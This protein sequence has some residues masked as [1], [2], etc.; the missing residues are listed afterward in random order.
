MATKRAMRSS[1]RSS[2]NRKTRNS[3]ASSKAILPRAWRS[4]VISSK[5]VACG[6]STRAPAAFE[7]ATARVGNKS[8]KNHQREGVHYKRP[9]RTPRRSKRTMSQ[10]AIRAATRGAWPVERFEA[11]TQCAGYWVRDPRGRKIGR[12]KRLFLNGSG[13]GGEG[14]GEGG[15]FWVRTD[16]FPASSP[17]PEAA[18]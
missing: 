13:G 12:L 17:S 7:K 14:G 3:R 9:S 5:P 15:G 4:T 8:G 2:S 1:S 11:P 18:W 6:A 10:T 16:P